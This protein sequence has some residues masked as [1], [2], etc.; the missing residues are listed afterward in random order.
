MICA[1]AGDSVWSCGD[2]ERKGKKY[3]WTLFGGGGRSGGHRCRRPADGRRKTHCR[4]E[5]ARE[6]RYRSRNR[7]A[8]RTRSSDNPVIIYIRVCVRAA[9]AKGLGGVGLRLEDA[10]H[11]GAVGPS[12][13]PTTA[14]RRRRR[15]R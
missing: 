9:P 1:R 7:R 4:Q 13:P 2:A 11:R 10:S 5:R 14:G 15:R 6:L 8:G 3:E 12:P